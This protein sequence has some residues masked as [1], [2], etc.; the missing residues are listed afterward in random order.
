MVT[1]LCCHLGVIQHKIKFESTFYRPADGV[2]REKHQNT[3]GGLWNNGET[4]VS[5]SWTAFAHERRMRGV[6]DLDMFHRALKNVVG[7]SSNEL[8]IEKWDLCIEWDKDGTIL[9]RF[10]PCC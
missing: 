9:K 1:R 4:D 3:D 7:C 5:V 8:F 6:G 10:F 2:L